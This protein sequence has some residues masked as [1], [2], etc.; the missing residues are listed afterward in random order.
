MA[1]TP[2][3]HFSPGFVARA[4]RCRAQWGF[5]P[6]GP[7]GAPSAVRR[8]GSRAEVEARGGSRCPSIFDDEQRRDRPRPPSARRVTAPLRGLWP[9]PGSE[10]PYAGRRRRRPPFA[11]IAGL[12]AAWPRLL[13]CRS[14]AMEGHRRRRGALNPDPWRPQ[15]T[16]LGA[17]AGPRGGADAYLTV[18]GA[19]RGE[20]TP[21]GAGH[22]R[23]Q[24]KAGEI[25]GLS[26]F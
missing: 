11:S 2:S 8:W 25:C 7:A 13:R 5:R 20:Q 9:G 15:R 10:W 24:Q 3:P 6:Q 17:P 18:R 22:R 1:P 4:A 19:P 23:P 12:S 21:L 14:S 16:T 26:Y